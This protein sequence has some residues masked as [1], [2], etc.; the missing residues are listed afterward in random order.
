MATRE[1][2]RMGNPILATM[3]QPIQPDD[4]ATL[5]D[6]IQDMI[7]TMRAANG[8]GLAAP[9][10]GLSMRLIVFEIPKNRQT[11]GDTNTPTSPQVLINP[12]ITHFDDEMELGWEGCLSIPG[13]K[14]RFR[15]T[16]RS[17]M[18][19]LTLKGIG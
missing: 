5:P 2:I 13:L 10:I 4:V 12:R 7:D 14:E 19:P 6:V 16:L 8:V 9:Q 17:H 15:G 18:M 3:A 1:I 11:A